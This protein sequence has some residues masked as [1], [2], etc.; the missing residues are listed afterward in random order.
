MPFAHQW[1]AH[2]IISPALLLPGLHALAVLIPKIRRQLLDSARQQVRIF[3]RLVARVILGLHTEDRRLDPQIDV[4]RNQRDSGGA[5]FLLQRQR[6]GQDRIVRAVPGQAVG[7]H[8]LHQLSL[9][10]QAAARRAL[11]VIDRHRGR[12]GETSIDLLLT[13][14]FHQLVEKAADLANVARRFGEAFFSRVE[15]LEDGH[16]NVD[17]VLFEAE[18]RGRVVHQHIR[19]QHEDAPLL[20][21][22]TAFRDRGP[23]GPHVA[24]HSAF[25]AARTCGGV[26]V[27]LDLA[28]NLPHHALAVDQESAALDTQEFLAVHALFLNHV[29]ELANFFVG[30]A[31]QFEWKCHLAFEFLV[32]LDDVGRDAAD[33]RLGF[34]ELRIGRGKVGALLGA[35]RRVVARIEINDDGA[36]GRIAQRPAAGRAFESELRRFLAD[37]DIAHERVQLFTGSKIASKFR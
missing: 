16:W 21:A 1:S 19:V 28:P 29:V 11:A 17:V 8:G 9:K 5:K 23:R 34:L 7:K 14:A 18:D 10:K 6:I 26:A 24:G 30:I 37:F 15:F 22:R 25:T 13:R 33:G 3:D 27:H 32:R 31:Q 35:P 4:F 2:P 20:L 36:A 12:Q